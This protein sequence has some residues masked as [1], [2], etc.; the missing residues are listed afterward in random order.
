MS[1]CVFHP[2]GT[3]SACLKPGNDDEPPAI[4]LTANEHHEIPRIGALPLDQ[5][6]RL[7]YSILKDV[8][9][10]KAGW[11]FLPVEEDQG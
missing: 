2:T 4:I 9:A 8:E 10:G 11:R 1:C 6:E 5:A 3:I 7:A